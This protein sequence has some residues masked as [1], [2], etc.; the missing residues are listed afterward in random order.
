MTG[1]ADI[2]ALGRLALQRQR[3]AWRAPHEAQRNCLERLLARSA[4]SGFGIAHGL[5]PGMTL[6]DW[7][8]A[9]PVRD[10]ADYAAW[11]DRISAGERDVLTV[12][13]VLAFELTGGSSGGRRVVPYTASLL[14]DFQELL[15]AWLADLLT[16]HP[17]I[18]H[19][20]AYFAVS[21]ALQRP[22]TRLGTVPVGLESDLAY[23]GP[24]I[25]AQ[26]GP[27]L[28]WHPSLAVA[29][30]AE[31]AR[32]TA[33]HLVASED[34]SLVSVWSPTFLSRLLDEV[35]TDEALPRLLHDGAHGLEPRPDRAR[36]LDRAR[37]SEGL[38]AALWPGL[39]LV[40]AWADAA[41]AR[42]AEALKSRLGGVGFQAKGLLAT[43][44]F[45][46]LP[47]CGLPFPLPALTGSLLEFEDPAGRLHL[48]HELETGVTYGLIVSTSGGL[49]RYRMGDRVRAMGLPE[50]SA[51]GPRLQMLRFEGRTA[52]CDLVGEKLDEAFVLT[53]LAGFAPGALLAAGEG[54]YDLWLD[55]GEADRMPPDFLTLLDARLRNNPQYDYARRL[56]Q[57]GPPQLRLCANLA[58]R[59]RSHRLSLGHRLSDI[60]PPALLPFGPLHPQAWAT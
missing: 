46:T 29:D 36:A 28:V 13:P 43:E 60:K 34:L 27:L 35:K 19:G 37:Q 50:P 30:E 42:P 17:G 26:L 49:Q 56:G 1:W 31:W 23:F 22:V 9:V 3:A 57:L 6:A 59:Y 8:A 33:L 2:A 10:A 41:S 58:G 18:A 21:P 53:C 7:R 16:A 4:R 20:R 40:S 52:G 25:A 5:R 14:A 38:V 51:E 54:R 39:T 45:F 44:G 55:P 15:S 47:L 24:Q 32:R 11:C 12:E 48:A